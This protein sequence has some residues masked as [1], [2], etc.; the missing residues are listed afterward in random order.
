MALACLAGQ[1]QLKRTR[2][3]H[4]KKRVKSPLNNDAKSINIGNDGT[5]IIA[6][7]K[8]INNLSTGPPTKP[9]I[10]PIIT[11]SRVENRATDIPIISE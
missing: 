3:I 4:T 2:T 8:N 9:D 11:P 7:I 10:E 5:A 1:G 6:S